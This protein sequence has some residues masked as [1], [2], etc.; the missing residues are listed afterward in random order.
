MRSNDDDDD[1]DVDVVVDLVVENFQGT[2]SRVNP[3]T[4]KNTKN[5][6]NRRNVRREIGPPD[7]ASK[8]NNGVSV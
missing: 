7:I 5:I 3:K 8:E 2:N 6:D 1:D 4:R